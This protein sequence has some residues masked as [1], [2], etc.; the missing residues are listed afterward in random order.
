[1]I[2]DATTAYQH[3]RILLPRQRLHIYGNGKT[4]K[5]YQRRVRIVID[6]IQVMRCREGRDIRRMNDSKDELDM[7][8]SERSRRLLAVFVIPVNSVESHEP[9]NICSA[10]KATKRML[11]GIILFVI[12]LML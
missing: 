11:R 8:E 10:T 12:S 9:L 2:D 6:N 5:E 1:M 7:S 3:S 4:F